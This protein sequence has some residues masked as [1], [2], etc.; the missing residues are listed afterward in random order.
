MDVHNGI[1]DIHNFIMNRDDRI[2]IAEIWIHDSIRDY[3]IVDRSIHNTIPGAI[4]ALNAGGYLNG[5]TTFSTIF[6]HSSI[7]GYPYNSYHDL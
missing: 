3:V 5:E 2:S 6:I 1:I 4:Q 7:Y